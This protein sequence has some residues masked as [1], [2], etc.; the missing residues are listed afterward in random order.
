VRRLLAE[1]AFAHTLVST[2][3]APQRTVLEI[4]WG[5]LVQHVVTPLFA[6]LARA[7]S[8][9]QNVGTAAGVVLIVVALVAL[10]FVIVRLALAFAR[11]GRRTPDARAAVALAGEIAVDA[12]TWRER[13][14]V[15]A[16]RADYGLAIAAL[17]MAALCVLD[18][19]AL[20]PFD[21]ART[22]GEYNRLVRRSR[23]LAA[24]PFASLGERFVYATYAR[25]RALPAD[26]DA[27]LASFAAF[28]PAARGGA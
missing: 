25:A 22:P 1:P 21:P 8:A 6:P 7:F 12:A 16:G 4:V 11:A 5:W 2:N 19:R 27:A 15:A 26:Y 28:E 20:V 23:A 13:A 9:A 17:W 14:S 10:A 3:A 18:E 24:A